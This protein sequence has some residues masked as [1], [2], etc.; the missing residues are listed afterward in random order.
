MSS[1]S[2]KCVKNKDKFCYCCA[3]FKYDDPELIT[4]SSEIQKLYFNIFS[5]GMHDLGK[6]FAPSKICNKC[7]YM[8]EKVNASSDASKLKFHIPAIWREPFSHPELCY[9]CSTN[10]SGLKKKHAHLIKYP[11]VEACIRPQL[12]N[13]F[14]LP[15]Q[16]KIEITVVRRKRRLDED[17]ADVDQLAEDEDENDDDE[18][19][20]NSEESED[21]ESPPRKSIYSTSEFNDI[22]RNFNMS[23]RDAVKLGKLFRW[24]NDLPKDKSTFYHQRKRDARFRPFFKSAGQTVWCCDIK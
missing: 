19:D 11:V 12:V 14:V 13:N 8:L 18:S 23:K 6:S 10:N 22:V 7:K 16:D 17:E 5:L 4:V 9:F 24:N 15:V 1:R 3:D 2:F 20:F 21:E